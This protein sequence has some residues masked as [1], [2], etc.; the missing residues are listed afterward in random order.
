MKCICQE[1]TNAV[2][3]YGKIRALW[4]TAKGVKA[5][6]TCLRWSFVTVWHD[7]PITELE[8]HDL[9]KTTL[10]E[11]KLLSEKSSVGLLITDL[12]RTGVGRT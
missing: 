3:L 2:S 12:G 11:G 1:Q 9:N 5:S 6:S 10:R 4:S 7:I 8:K